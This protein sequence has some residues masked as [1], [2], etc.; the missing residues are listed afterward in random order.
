METTAGVFGDLGSTFRA[1]CS[2]SSVTST[3]WMLLKLDIPAHNYLPLLW[4]IDLAGIWSLIVTQKE[5]LLAGGLQLCRLLYRCMD[6]NFTAKDVK[7]THLWL[8]TSECLL[9]SNPFFFFSPMLG[10]FCCQKTAH[11]PCPKSSQSQILVVVVFACY[12]PLSS[13][14]SPTLEAVPSKLP[15]IES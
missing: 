15:I 11:S 1:S 7:M 14:R 5:T 6:I 2:S 4:N 8:H 13:S 12:L 3:S 9:P 10:L